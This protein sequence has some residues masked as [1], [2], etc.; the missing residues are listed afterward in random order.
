MVS[1]RCQEN[2]YF[3]HKI[4]L[5]MFPLLDRNIPHVEDKILS[6]LDPKGL[7]NSMLVCKEW[8]QK[9]RPFRYE[10]YATI[11]REKGKI[12]LQIAV[13]RRYD[14]LI[15]FFLRD[16]QVNVNETNK[17]D[18]YTALMEAAIHGQERIT[19]LLLEREDIEVNIRSKYHGCT[20]LSL[21][22][23]HGHAGVVKILLER[24]NILVNDRG[25]FGYTALM[26][27]AMMRE[28]SAV[29]ELLKHPNIDVNIKDN[30]GHTALSNTRGKYQRLSNTTLDI[31]QSLNK[32]KIIKMLEE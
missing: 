31:E 13:I 21:A 6:Y 26:E 23:G 24:P 29:E 16:K 3:A 14:Q 10:W 28:A 4:K 17:W 22:A 12:P 20:A 27:A 11:L 8:C 9:V 25:A 5:K 30:N 18:G 19:R 32:E 2:S 7:T 15:S 1:H